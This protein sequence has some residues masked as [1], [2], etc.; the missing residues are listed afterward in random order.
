MDHVLDLA[1]GGSSPKPE[2]EEEDQLI[3]S[4]LSHAG[5]LHVFELKGGQVWY[6]WQK[7][8]E[9]S[10]HG[11]QEGKRVAG[12][13]RFCEAKDVVSIASEVSASGAIQLFGRKKDGSTV[14]T[15]QGP[16]STAWAGGEPGK[17]VAAFRSFAPAP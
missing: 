12:M 8:G 3:A 17:A 14:Y 5:N 11:G 2:E 13:S 15:Y 4:A 1:R 10:W 16:N 6:T 9:T 7:K